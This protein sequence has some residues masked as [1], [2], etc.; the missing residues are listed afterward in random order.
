M[1]CEG[2]EEEDVRVD[3]KEVVGRSSPDMEGVVSLSSGRDG[4]GQAHSDGG[5]QRGQRRQS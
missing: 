3:H 2:E 5:G 1:L 4:D